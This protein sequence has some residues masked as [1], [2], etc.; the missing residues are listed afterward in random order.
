MAENYNLIA[1]ANG[2]TKSK[3]VWTDE[4]YD[5][6]CSVFQITPSSYS[7]YPNS[8]FRTEILMQFVPFFNQ[9]PTQIPDTDRWPL[10]YTNWLAANPNG[11]LQFSDF[12][13]YCLPAPH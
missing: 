7:K 2:W 5:I 11:F 3:P 1:E 6:E 9:L 10:N 4:F 13:M 12:L 8:M